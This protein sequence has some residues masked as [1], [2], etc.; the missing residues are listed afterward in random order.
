MACCCFAIRQEIGTQG[1][2][3]HAIVVRTDYL[4]AISSW[5]ISHYEYV[6]SPTR[7]LYDAKPVLF[8]I[9]RISGRISIFLPPCY[10][11]I[12]AEGS[13]FM[14][15]LCVSF[16]QQGYK[17]ECSDGFPELFISPNYSYHQISAASFRP[18]G[19]VLMGVCSEVNVPWSFQGVCIFDYSN[20]FKAL[21]LCSAG[22]LC[23]T[24]PVSFRWEWL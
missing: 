2:P 20:S 7:L 13:L 11:V 22:L 12:S 16:G 19:K 1:L 5:F 17:K 24:C 15:C 23:F 21:L 9:S 10:P 8:R 3:Q 6:F 18:N 14:T 4:E